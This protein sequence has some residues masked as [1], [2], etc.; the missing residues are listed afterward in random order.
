M[1]IHFCFS[2]AKIT[3]KIRETKF[4]EQNFTHTPTARNQLYS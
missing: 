4:R 2:F 1:V 3:T